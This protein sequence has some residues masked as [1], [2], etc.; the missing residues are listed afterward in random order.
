M[1]LNLKENIH[2]REAEGPIKGN[3]VSKWDSSIYRKKDP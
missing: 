2:I 3:C 1:G